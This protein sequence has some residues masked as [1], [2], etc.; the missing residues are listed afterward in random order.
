MYEER[1]CYLSTAFC[2]KLGFLRQ[3]ALRR[4]ARAPIVCW[5]LLALIVPICS[6]QT[7]QDYYC[8]GNQITGQDCPH[9]PPKEEGLSLPP[10]PPS[11]PLP[12][13]QWKI[14]R[15]FQ[16]DFLPPTTLLVIPHSETWLIDKSV[17]KIESRCIIVR[18]ALIAASW[19]RGAAGVLPF[20][21]NLE[22][23]LN[24]E[25]PLPSDPLPDE[26]QQDHF[27]SGRWDV[28]QDNPATLAVAK[29]GQLLLKGKDQE[30][31]WTTLAAPAAKGSA[32]LTVNEDLADW[33]TEA[34]EVVL[35]STDFDP[36][37]T[38]TLLVKVNPSNSKELQ[39]QSSTVQWYHHGSELSDTIDVERAPVGLLTHNIKIVGKTET[40]AHSVA[41]PGFDS[42]VVSG[43][44][45]RNMG[46]K[47]LGNYPWHWHMTGD[48]STGVERAI[49]D[50]NSIHDSIFRCL[51]I[52]QT[53]GTKVRNNV[54]Y[55]ISGHCVYIE[56]GIWEENNVISKNLVLGVKSVREQFHHGV[57]TSDMLTVPGEGGG[58]PLSQSWVASFW[59]K[60]LKNTIQDNW[61]GSS[62]GVGFWTAPC[63]FVGAINT[64]R[65]MW[66]GLPTFPA[67]AATLGF[68]QQFQGF[69]GNTMHSI[70]VGFFNDG[71]KNFNPTFRSPP[72]VTPQITSSEERSRCRWG[73]TGEKIDVLKAFSVEDLTVFKSQEVGFWVR[74]AR[75]TFIGGTWS[76]TRNG[77]E[78]LQGGTQPEGRGV[79]RRMTFIGYSANK[80][81]V[82]DTSLLECETC[83]DATCKDATQCKSQDID[84]TRTPGGTRVMS[85]ARHA[86][87][88]TYEYNNWYP[89]LHVSF[90]LYDGPDVFLGTGN[91]PQD[92]STYWNFDDE[93]Y[94]FAAPRR[95][96]TIFLMTPATGWADL[97]GDLASQTPPDSDKVKRPTVEDM[98]CM[99]YPRKV[100]PLAE[101]QSEK[102]KESNLVLDDNRR[103]MVLAI[104]SNTYT[105]TAQPILEQNTR[106]SNDDTAGSF[107]YGMCYSPDTI[108][109]HQDGLFSCPMIYFDNEVIKQ[110]MNVLCGS[111]CGPDASSEPT[112]VVDATSVP[113]AVAPAAV[114]PKR[115]DLRRHSWRGRR[116]R[117]LQPDQPELQE[118]PKARAKGFLE[119]RLDM[120]SLLQLATNSEALETCSEEGL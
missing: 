90:V 5:V 45:F 18:G 13:G 48:L 2:V 54:M 95:A 22:I 74:A 86:T 76:D 104:G 64:P 97:P 91:R 28:T 115:P 117:L 118:H 21:G 8:K 33:G 81:N 78:T 114:A 77:I 113:T 47:H 1:T 53:S 80:G 106:P 75:V 36:K 65:D 93:R 23:L 92:Q 68:H 29:D 46:R 17:T 71:A 39:V 120:S 30:R 103:N 56:D 35:G 51:S 55:N 10:Q 111:G 49:F 119:P 25:L 19:Q 41:F 89:P 38:E 52:H 101:D 42:T 40:G 60:S 63:N 31:T 116:W 43:V 108:T 105:P 58:S 82:D 16:E 110:A 9:D 32:T 70:R 87:E 20:A 50:G 11:P 26:C 24:D 88:D 112:A 4:M 107:K 44:E 15:K 73:G 14:K 37:Y 7:L 84:T 85:N 83:T 27:H 57:E 67:F 3:Q 99:V 79:Y 98:L 34:V 72:T 102:E 66:Q 96:P 6:L 61:V 12:S 69:E 62:F 59:I 100:F 94:C 109:A